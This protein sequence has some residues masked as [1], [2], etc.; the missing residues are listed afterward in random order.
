MLF[1]EVILVISSFSN[2]ILILST[3]HIRLVSAPTE[4]Y[5]MRRER[6]HWTK[7]E[8][9]MLICVRYDLKITAAD[10]SLAFPV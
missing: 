3:S 5:V 4:Q 8:G 10:E 1:W 2:I 7:T 9:V 6:S